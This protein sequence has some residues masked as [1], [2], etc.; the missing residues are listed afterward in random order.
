MNGFNVR[1]CAESKGEAVPNP[2]VFFAQWNV[3]G[4]CSFTPG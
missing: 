1:P 4:R 2:N 3:V